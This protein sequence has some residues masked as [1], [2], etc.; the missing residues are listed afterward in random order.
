MF[1]VIFGIFVLLHGLVHLWYVVLSQR[2]VEFQ[3][4]MGWT[5]ESWL[6]SS[7]LSDAATRTWATVA[8]AL[9]TLGFVI[10]GVGILARQTWWQPA[11][12]VS[13]AFSSVIVVLFWD[14][15]LEMLV[16]KGLLG[17]V[18]SVALLISLLVF[19]W[20]SL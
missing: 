19:D 17:F 7:F 13:A 10:A 8:Y 14:G 4:Q 6:F 1:R 16:E 20:P 9:A 12:I 11:L 2:L 3:A 18:I 15:G 5:G